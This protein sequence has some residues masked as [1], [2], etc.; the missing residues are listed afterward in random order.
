MK[1]TD[2]MDAIDAQSNDAAEDQDVVN[3]PGYM[4][5]S[6]SIIQEAL[7]NGF[8]VLQLENGDIVTTGTKVI[9]NTYRWNKDHKEMLRIDTEE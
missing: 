1:I 9:V 6:S 3:E 8:D 2:V 5:S 7:K 4:E